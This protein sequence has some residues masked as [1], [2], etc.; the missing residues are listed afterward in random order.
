MSSAD[1][2]LARLGE[3]V[4]IAANPDGGWGYYRG[5]TSRVEPTSWA[6]LALAADFGNRTARGLVPHLSFLASRRG[7]SGL[8]VDDPGVPPNLAFNG[9][10]ALALTPLARDVDSG[11]LDQVLAGILGIRGIR[12]PAAP[13]IRQDNSLQGWPWIDGTFSWAEP[14]S[15]CLL[16]L[17][18]CARRN[19]RARQLERGGPEPLASRI[20]EAER[21]LIDRCCPTGGWNFGNANVMGQ[22]LRPYV[23]T[24]ALGLLAMQDRRDHPVVARSLDYLYAHRLSELS[25]LAL[26]L[27]LICLQVYGIPAPD[28]EDHLLA[29]FERT[30]FLGNYS[31]MALAW[32][33]LTSAR[34]GLE[35]FRL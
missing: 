33:S 23:P 32:H 17:K 20:D 21:L 6:V 30:G 15:W 26:A 4:A 11:L 27:T 16:A 1:T 13:D 3:A 9:L 7:S 28:V 18:R 29:Q 14:T 2:R 10:A 19:Q 25:G 34:H 24:T 5:T 35:A 8:L 12:L 31:V 22:D